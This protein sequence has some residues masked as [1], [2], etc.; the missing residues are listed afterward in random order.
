MMISIVKG[1]TNFSFFSLCY[2]WDMTWVSRLKFINDPTI[3]LPLVNHSFP[4]LHICKCN[5]ITCFTHDKA[6]KGLG[7]VILFARSFAIIMGHIFAKAD[8]KRVDDHL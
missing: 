4:S 7:C 5:V 8:E 3:N 6:T 2:W 1:G